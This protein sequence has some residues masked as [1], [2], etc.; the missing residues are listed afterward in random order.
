[1]GYEP[2]AALA[3]AVLERAKSDWQYLE[4]QEEVEV[5]LQGDVL[6]NFL[7][8]ARIDRDSYLK[9]V[10]SQESRWRRPIRAKV[11]TQCESKAREYEMVTR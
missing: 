11:G 6:D 10:R 1:M 7:F 3:N 8:L 5:F 4:D 9:E 2:C